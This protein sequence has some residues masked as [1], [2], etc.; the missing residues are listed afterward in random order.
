MSVMDFPSNGLVHAL[1]WS[2]HTMIATGASYVFAAFPS[3]FKLSF[4][5]TTINLTGCKLAAVGAT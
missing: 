2:A 3:L 4:S 5:C 1:E